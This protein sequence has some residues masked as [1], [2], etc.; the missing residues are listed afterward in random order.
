MSSKAIGKNLKLSV[1]SF[2]SGNVEAG[3]WKSLTNEDKE[4]EK[5]GQN[6]GNKRGTLRIFVNM[7]I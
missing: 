4:K 7:N 2:G 3:G 5:G 1:I 6:I